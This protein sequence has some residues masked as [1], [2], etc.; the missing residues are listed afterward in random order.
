MGQ[1]LFL[2]MELVLLAWRAGLGELHPS[3]RTPLSLLRRGE[4]EPEAVLGVSPMSTWRGEVFHRDFLL[5]L[6]NLIDMQVYIFTF[7]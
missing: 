3:S 6:S 2:F 7:F 4:G 5:P 1:I